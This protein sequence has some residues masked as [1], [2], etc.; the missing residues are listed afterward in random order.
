ML[1]L[2]SGLLLGLTVLVTGCNTVLW[3]NVGVFCVTV[4]IFLGTVFLSRNRPAPSSSALG[5]ISGSTSS[6]ASGSAS[7]SPSPRS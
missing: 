3:G 1:A 2:R 5:S 6:S 4:G 7:G